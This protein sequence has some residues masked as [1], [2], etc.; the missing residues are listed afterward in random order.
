VIKELQRAMTNSLD[1]PLNHCYIHF[2]MLMTTGL[3]IN[4]SCTI[5][6]KWTRVTGVNIQ[7]CEDKNQEQILN[8]LSE[9]FHAD[10]EK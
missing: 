10:H 9:T 1:I 7:I 3:G 4:I 5:F 6:F 8:S 2:S